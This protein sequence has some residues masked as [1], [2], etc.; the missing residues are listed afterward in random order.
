[1]T[2]L[3][4]EMAPDKLEH[5][6]E[7]AMKWRPIRWKMVP[8]IV[9]ASLVAVFLYLS[10]SVG[11]SLVFFTLRHFNKSSPTFLQVL[12]PLG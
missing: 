6:A 4:Y 3:C 10:F 2:F 9:L 12:K 1:M 5:G 8:N 7:H 11:I